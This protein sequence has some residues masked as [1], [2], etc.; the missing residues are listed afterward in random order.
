MIAR[1]SGWCKLHSLF[2][3]H[4]AFNLRSE[5][6]ERRKSTCAGHFEMGLESARTCE[7][8]AMPSSSSVRLPP[9]K[10]RPAADSLSGI[11][12]VCLTSA[13]LAGAYF[14][15]EVLI[16]LALAGLIT[17][18]LTPLVNKLQRWLGNVTAVLLTMTTVLA[19]TIALGWMLGTQAVD[20]A[21]QLPGYKENIRTKLRSFQVPTGG[22]LSKLSETVDD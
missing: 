8:R 2:F 15:Q 10:R 16:P 21:G 12:A 18:L 4:R 3:V 17:F 5:G 22:V 14:G 19:A 1:E 11:F 13:L 9:R 6:R 20:L 7:I